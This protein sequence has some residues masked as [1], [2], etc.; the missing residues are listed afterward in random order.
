M[1]WFITCTKSLIIKAHSKNFDE[2]EQA[3]DE[4]VHEEKN[5][6]RANQLFVK[7]EL[8]KLNQTGKCCCAVKSEKLHVK[9]TF[10][11][12]V[13]NLLADHKQI[14]KQSVWQ[15]IIAQKNL[16]RCKQMF[17]NKKVLI[18]TCDNRNTCGIILTTNKDIGHRLRIRQAICKFRDRV[19]A[20]IG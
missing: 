10:Y 14:I 13:I 9:T 6:T 1:T 8:C 5:R 19:F 4:N 15:L 2:G 3:C 11:K 20:I 7:S 16:L 12:H 18:L 17:S